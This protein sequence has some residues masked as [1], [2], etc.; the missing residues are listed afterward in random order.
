MKLGTRMSAL[1]LGLL[2]PIAGATYAYPSWPE[3]VGL[4][5]WNV[6]EL[7]A[8]MEFEQHHAMELAARLEAS[9]QRIALREGAIDELVEG[10]ITPREAVAVFLN[11][12]RSYPEALA[13]ARVLLPAGTDEQQAAAQVIAYLT[14]RSEEDAR[15]SQAFIARLRHE[16]MESKSAANTRE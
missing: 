5:F 6:P 10:S 16:L 4:D 14:G 15:I 7:E 8:R 2:A 13:A 3:S 1:V 9:R 12:N 11:V